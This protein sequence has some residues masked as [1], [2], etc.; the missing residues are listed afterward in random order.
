MGIIVDMTSSIYRHE[1][2]LTIGQVPFAAG[3]IIVRNQIRALR[4]RHKARRWQHF[5]TLFRRRPDRNLVAS[6]RSDFDVAGLT[7]RGAN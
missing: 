3:T 4:Q 5:S 1:P 2:V 7:Y 6:R